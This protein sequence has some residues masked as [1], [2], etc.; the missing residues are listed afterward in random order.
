M[1]EGQGAGAGVD[2]RGDALEFVEEQHCNI[3]GH[4]IF[5]SMSNNSSVRITCLHA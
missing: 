4:L 1:T 5:A 3:A 2:L